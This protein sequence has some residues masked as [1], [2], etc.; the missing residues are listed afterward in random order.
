M[1]EKAGIEE[2]S[3]R[4]FSLTFVLIVFSLFLVN[5]SASFSAY[6]PVPYHTVSVVSKAAILVAM[7]WCIPDIIRRINESF[8]IYTL[9]GL[10]CVSVI[11]LAFFPASNP[12]FKETLITFATTIFPTM[13]CASSIRDYE[14]LYRD[15]SV[16]S[17]VIGLIMFAALFLVGSARN[18]FYSMGL[19]NSLILPA[20]VLVHD[21]NAGQGTLLYRALKGVLLAGLLLS[22]LL[23]GSR[24]AL[25]AII[26]F[27]VY[28]L[29]FRNAEGRTAKEYLARAGVIA[30]MLLFAAFYRQILQFFISISAR[31]GVT[32]RTLALLENDI[33][34]DSGRLDNW[35]KLLHRISDAPFAFRGIDAEYLVLG[36]YSHNIF[37][38]LCYNLG[39]VLGLILSVCLIVEIIRTLRE[40]RHGDHKMRLIMLFVWFPLLLWSGSLWTSMYF[41]VWL[42][43]DKS[44]RIRVSGISRFRRVRQG[45]L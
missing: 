6:V 18:S 16:I 11:Q 22:I 1:R 28:W 23:Y 39:I 14:R 8:L 19:A 30:A 34:H 40:A 21:I 2:R 45:K 35:A 15:I 26:V 44:P 12:Y 9:L 4:K 7:I 29:L 3:D 38:T 37:L 43:M 32:S 31:R 24:G 27:A 13:I 5:L 17:V 25:L 20:I 42:T 33:M 36:Q 41:W 10:I